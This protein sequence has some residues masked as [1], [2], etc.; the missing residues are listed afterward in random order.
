MIL[1]IPARGGSKGVPR[2]NLIK[3]GGIPLVVRGIMAG[4]NANCVSRVVV[5]TDDN[6]IGELSKKAGAEVIVRPKAISGDVVMPDLAVS[7]V[8]N[9]IKS[10]NEPLSDVTCFMQP[11][12]PFTTSDD[13][14][15][16][17]EKFC[18]NSC[19]SMFSGVLTHSFLWKMNGL[20]YL[21]PVNH[22]STYRIGRQ[23]LDSQFMETG[24][25]YL[26]K[27]K[28]FLDVQHRFFGNIGVYE[29]PANRSI[30]IDDYF[31]LEMANIFADNISRT[32]K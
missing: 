9:H 17:Y 5:S 28:G 3:V 4:L 30:D 24:A 14:D 7:H 18:K 31:D 1:V 11:T 29:M 19:D 6:E 23:Q 2:K 12:S 10:S 8:L 25:F 15:C 32:S 26:F 27:T 13:I 21:N 20:K 16:A 22:D